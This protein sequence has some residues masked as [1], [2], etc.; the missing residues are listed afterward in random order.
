V[1]FGSGAQFCSS[2]F[3]YAPAPQK[4]LRKRLSLIHGAQG[5]MVGEA[6]TSQKCCRCHE[7][8]QSVRTAKV[9]KA[10]GVNQALE[11]VGC[12]EVWAMQ[13]RTEENGSKVLA[14]RHQCGLQHPEHLYPALGR[15]EERPLAFRSHHVPV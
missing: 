5:T 14:S 13:I 1:A 10:T 3:G 9:D 7:P 11:G 12:Q 15:D 4:R 2:S 6:H 8:L